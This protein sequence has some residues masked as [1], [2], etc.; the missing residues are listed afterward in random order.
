MT[1]LDPNH[2]F[3]NFYHRLCHH[4]V[5]KKKKKNQVKKLAQAP[6]L[7]RCTVCAEWN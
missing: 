5:E 6:L 3:K 1:K 4:N 2:P 7:N